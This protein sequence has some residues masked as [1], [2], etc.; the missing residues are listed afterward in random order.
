MPT[1]LPTRLREVNSIS[2]GILPLWCGLPL[3]GQ[4]T[5]VGAAENDENDLLANMWTYLQLIHL[6]RTYIIFLD[7]SDFL[8]Y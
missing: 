3:G 8:S 4:Y 6:N 5:F 2:P 7:G 1:Q